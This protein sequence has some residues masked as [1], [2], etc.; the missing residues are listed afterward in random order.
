[1]TN[2]Q[3]MSKLPYR[4]GLKRWLLPF[5]VLDW[6]S[7]AVWGD[8]RSDPT[9]PPSVWLAANPSTKAAT[10]VVNQDDL[11]GIQLLVIGRSRKF[12]VIDGQVVRP[13][14]TYNGSKV[15]SIK[16]D[17]VVVQ[18]ASKS[19]KVTP[20][21]EKRVARSITLKKSG[22]AARKSKESVNGNGG[23]Q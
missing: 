17:E 6:F 15:L 1:M 22:Q 2:P 21:V 7:G 18:D 23:S 5:L 9:T 16:P 10:S 11:S 3:K 8:T 12:A 20:G 13:G 4:T 14:E 19:L